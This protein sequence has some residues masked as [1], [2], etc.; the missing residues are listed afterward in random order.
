MET[1]SLEAN[2]F[3]AGLG[4]FCELL[5]ALGFEA[6]NPCGKSHKNARVRGWA[7]CRNSEERMAA[8]IFAWLMS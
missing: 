5:V 1:H 4:N 6:V 8:K 3:V 7:D 2:R